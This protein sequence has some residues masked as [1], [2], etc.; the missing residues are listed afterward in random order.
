MK[1]LPAETSL[2]ATRL[3]RAHNPPA[4]E[5]Q[6]YRG[7][8]RWDFG[9]TCA[10]CFLHEQDLMDG[11]AEGTG[12]IWIEH[13]EL[14]HGSEARAK[15]YSNCLLSCRFCNNGR[16]RIPATARDGTGKLLD[17]TEV[18]WSEYFELSH[19][20]I[21]ARDAGADAQYTFKVYGL[22]DKRK[23]VLRESRERRFAS[24][25][26]V[27][28]K[29]KEL[30]PKLMDR[31]RQTA[32]PEK[33]REL[34]E[35]GLELEQAYKDAMAEIRRYAAIPCDAPESCLCGGARELPE[36]LSSQLQDVELA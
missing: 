19:H 18:V 36:W 34:V 14:K 4:D 5:Y 11:G 33:K 23:G 28:A 8:I 22:G 25:R 12:L 20:E 7:C 2:P 29:M 15:D 3:A 30:V 31:A 1:L 35:A 17:P 32:D 6:R 26:R 27:E 16:S 10:L 21:T 24:F 13:H 9:F